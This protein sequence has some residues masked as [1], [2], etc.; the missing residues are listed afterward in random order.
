MSGRPGSSK[1]ASRMCIVMPSLLVM[2]PPVSQR[3]DDAEFRSIGNANGLFHIPTKQKRRSTGQGA[4]SS[5]D[6]QRPEK[7]WVLRHLRP[8]AFAPQASVMASSEQ[9]DVATIIPV[10]CD[11]VKE[12]ARLHGR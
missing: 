3:P 7:R 1:P 4:K 11:G 10:S 2:V 12:D 9:D 8:R 6:P 5:L